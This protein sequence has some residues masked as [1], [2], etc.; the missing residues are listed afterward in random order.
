MANAHTGLHCTPCL[1]EEPTVFCWAFAFPWWDMDTRSWSMW[2]LH[3]RDRTITALQHAHSCLTIQTCSISVTPCSLSLFHTPKCHQTQTTTGQ[4][5]RRLWNL[6]GLSG[7]W[8]TFSISGLASI[9]T[10]PLCRKMRE[11][12]RKQSEEWKTDT[13][14]NREHAGNENKGSQVCVNVRQA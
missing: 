2:T 6:W 7:W 9:P 1:C 14:G 8:D 4:T 12:M 3:G 5:G 10:N 13:R 11:A